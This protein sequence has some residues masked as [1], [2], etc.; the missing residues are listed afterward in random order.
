M[1]F[2]R[3]ISTSWA[4]SGC[5]AFTISRARRGFYLCSPQ[6]LSIN[7]TRNIDGIVLFPIINQLLGNFPPRP[8]FF[9][10]SGDSSPSRAATAFSLWDVACIFLCNWVPA[11]FKESGRHRVRGV[12]CS[13]LTRIIIGDSCLSLSPRSCI[14]RRHAAFCTLSINWDCPHDGEGISP[15]QKD[16]SSSPI[17]CSLS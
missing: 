4:S 2:I 12:V 7:F 15:F 8:Y 17:S 14:I 1:H 6:S 3:N 10:R 5:L 9:F 16:K 13:E 11:A